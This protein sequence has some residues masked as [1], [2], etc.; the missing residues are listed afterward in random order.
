[1]LLGLVVVNEIVGAVMALPTVMPVPVA[2]VSVTSKPPVVV[3][4]DSVVKAAVS[5]TLIPLAAFKV[6]TG[7]DTTGATALPIA[8]LVLVKLTVVP[9]IDDELFTPSILPTAVTVT[10]P[11]PLPTT[12][13]E[14]NTTLPVAPVL[15]IVVVADWALT[16]V[17][18]EA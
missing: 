2:T 13:P 16:T 1:M 15:F 5:V 8:P 11:A 17:S 9:S 3:E 18:V 14:A 7:V 6:K 12:P 10:T 4:P